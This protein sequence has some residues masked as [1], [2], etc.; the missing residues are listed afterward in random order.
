[1]KKNH[2]KRNELVTCFENDYKIIYGLTI[3]FNLLGC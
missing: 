1:M 3:D 2:F